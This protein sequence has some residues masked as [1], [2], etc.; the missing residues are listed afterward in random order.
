MHYFF[1][2]GVAAS[3]ERERQV[4]V[5]GTHAPGRNEVEAAEQPRLSGIGLSDPALAELAVVAVAR[6]TSCNWMQASSSS[7]ARGE[8]PRPGCRCQIS[9]VFHSEKARRATRI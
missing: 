8:L 4:E 5:V 2:S 7:T 3:S 6:M 9:R 1:G